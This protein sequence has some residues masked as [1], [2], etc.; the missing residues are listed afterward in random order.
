LHFVSHSPCAIEAP[1]ECPTL[2]EANAAVEAALGRQDRWWRFGVQSPCSAFSCSCIAPMPAT[3][4]PLPP[5]DGRWAAE[6]KWDGWRALVTVDGT[7]PKSTPGAMRH[8]FNAFLNGTASAEDH[9]SN[10]DGMK[11]VTAKHSAGL[12]LWKATLL[13]P[14]VTFGA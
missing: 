1:G 12:S 7:I 13:P 5:E 8:H 9:H 3:S 11:Q 6:V 14:S 10:H 4:G 2:E